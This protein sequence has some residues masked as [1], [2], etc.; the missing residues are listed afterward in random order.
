MTGTSVQSSKGKKMGNR[1]VY[2]LVKD[3]QEEVE[4]R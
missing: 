1:A 2:Y 3:G 4:E